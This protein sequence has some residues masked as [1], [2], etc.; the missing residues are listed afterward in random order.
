VYSIDDIASGNLVPGCNMGDV[1]WLSL[2]VG[3]EADDLGERD[4]P[5]L[6]PLA[7]IRHGELNDRIEHQ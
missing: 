6:F 5:D 2:A 7:L 1:Q 4:R 3:L